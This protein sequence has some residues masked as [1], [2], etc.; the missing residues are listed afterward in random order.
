MPRINIPL[1]VSDEGR[2]T[3]GT[4]QAF[5]QNVYVNKN[6]NGK[7]EI[8]KRPGLNATSG[9]ALDSTVKGSWK[10]HGYVAGSTRV[11]FGTPAYG[12]NFTGDSWSTEGGLFLQLEAAHNQCS[13]EGNHIRPRLLHNRLPIVPSARYPPPRKG[14]CHL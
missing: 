4:K 14:P 8:I 12:S 5:L 6:A 13:F 9:S 1:V 10:E 3:A 2:D 7:I 11:S